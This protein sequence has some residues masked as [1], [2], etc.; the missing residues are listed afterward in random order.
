VIGRKSLWII[1]SFVALAGI[2]IAGG[3]FYDMYGRRSASRVVSGTL[4]GYSISAVPA[5]VKFVLEAKDKEQM[6]DALRAGFEVELMDNILWSNRSFEVK[7]RL[8]NGSSLYC[9]LYHTPEWD[10]KCWE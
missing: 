2:A 7:V 1:A 5:D 8:A 6:I 9:D 10:L 3:C 4:A